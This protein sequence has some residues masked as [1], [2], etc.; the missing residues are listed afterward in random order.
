MTTRAEVQMFGPNEICN[1][2]TSKIEHIGS[3]TVASF[4]TGRVRGS[5]FL[6][7]TE[8][9]LRELVKPLGERKEIMKLVESYR[10]TR[11]SCLE[12]YYYFYIR[13]E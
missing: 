3:D 9:D 10:P 13:I 12:Y 2:L 4:E 5:V 6:D 8:T 11:V 7:L 1:L